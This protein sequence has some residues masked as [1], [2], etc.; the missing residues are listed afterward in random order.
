MKVKI[1]RLFKI[2]IIIVL[3]CYYIQA[4][5]LRIYNKMII[6]ILLMI[7]FVYLLSTLIFKE[8]YNIKEKIIKIVSSSIML[9]V[10]T[11]NILAIPSFIIE[12]TNEKKIYKKFSKNNEVLTLYINDNYTNYEIVY[13]KNYYLLFQCHNT[14]INEYETINRNGF[15]K[16]V[17][18]IDLSSIYN[19]IKNNKINRCYKYYNY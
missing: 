15:L 8:T 6:N 17:D 3:T 5:Y 16:K 9:A 2:M 11:I 18:N 19:Q 14:V 13:S 12:N 7:L 1:I 10:I 4:F